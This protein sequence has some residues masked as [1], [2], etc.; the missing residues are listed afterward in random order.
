M[1]SW[2]EKAVKKAFKMPSIN[3]ITKRSSSIT[4]A[5][6]SAISIIEKPSVEDITEVLKIFGMSPSTMS[7]CYCGNAATEW[8]H[9]KPL[10]VDRKPTGYPTSI[11]NLVPSCNKCNQSKGNNDWEAWMRSNIRIS[12]LSDLDIRIGKIKKFQKWAEC[13]PVNIEEA[14][15][16]DELNKYLAKCDNIL[17]LMQEAQLEAI[18]I[19]P[20]VKKA[21][22][23]K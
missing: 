22:D 7:C 18:K 14:V 20:K 16:V 13:T 15:G 1:S 4:N 9:L 19:K 5:F 17:R 23:K 8:D 3:T 21:Y 11:K 2:D 6:I 10:V 12:K